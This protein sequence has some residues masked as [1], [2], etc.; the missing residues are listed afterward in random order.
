MT[1]GAQVLS[2]LCAPF[3]VSPVKV[4]QE[5]GKARASEAAWSPVRPGT[6]DGVLRDL[7]W[8]FYLPQRTQVIYLQSRG[9]SGTQDS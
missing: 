7:I 6:L 2:C 4:E 9:R 3:Q 5:R 8:A 1:S